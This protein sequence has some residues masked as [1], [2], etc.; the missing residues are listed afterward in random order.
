MKRNTTS[1][2]RKALAIKQDQI[3]EINLNLNVLIRMK[4]EL[5]REIEESQ[6][7]EGGGGGSSSGAGEMDPEFKRQLNAKYDVVST[8]IE[9]KLDDIANIEKNF[10]DMSKEINQISDHNIR[11]VPLPLSLSLSINFS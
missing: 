7:F 1:V 11:F 10:D 3:S 2:L 5:E 4:K 6:F 8:T 9:H